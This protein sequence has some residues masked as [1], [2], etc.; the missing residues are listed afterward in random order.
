M[1]TGRLCASLPGGDIMWRNN[2]L[3]QRQLVEVE[4]Q[5]VSSAEDGHH[6]TQG[7][8]DE[9]A[10]VAA[11]HPPPNQAQE[12]PEVHAWGERGQ[13]DPWTHTHTHIRTTTVEKKSKLKTTM[14]RPTCQPQQQRHHHLPCSVHDGWQQHLQPSRKHDQLLDK[15]WRA[16]LNGQRGLLGAVRGRAPRL[17]SIFRLR[18]RRLHFLLGTSTPVWSSSAIEMS[19]TANNFTAGTSGSV[20]GIPFSWRLTW[21]GGRRSLM[22][23]LRMKIEEMRSPKS[24]AK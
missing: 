20:G 24:G 12:R 1:A 10:Y 14:L 4:H 19:S 18:I 5:Q 6:H 21:G 3:R 23:S 2:L 13:C 22:Q 11:E 7:A 15:L 8:E 16:R 9:H 17:A